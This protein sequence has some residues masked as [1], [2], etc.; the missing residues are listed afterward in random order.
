[1]VVVLLAS[2]GQVYIIIYYFIMYFYVALLVAAR[3]HNFNRSI[4]QISKIVK[5]SE[6][7]IRKR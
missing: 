4:K 6:G 1:M 3:L 2:V 7:T 5:L